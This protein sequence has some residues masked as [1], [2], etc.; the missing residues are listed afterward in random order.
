M[1]SELNRALKALD[2]AELALLDARLTVET[3]DP[4]DTRLRACRAASD[5]VRRLRDAIGAKRDLDSIRTV[6]EIA[7]ALLEIQ[8]DEVGDDE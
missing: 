3:D 1:R 6:S 2:A 8:P 7:A 4:L 5:C